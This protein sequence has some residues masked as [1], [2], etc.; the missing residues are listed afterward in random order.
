MCVD[1]WVDGCEWECVSVSR[2]APHLAAPDRPET[3]DGACCA[4]ARGMGGREGG[5][6]RTCV[7]VPERVVGCQRSS[8]RTSLGGGRALVAWGSVSRLSM[9]PDDDAMRAYKLCREHWSAAENSSTEDN[10]ANR[11]RCSS[12]DKPPS[13][14]PSSFVRACGRASGGVR[15]GPNGDSSPGG[16]RQGRDGTRRDPELAPFTGSHHSSP[17]TTKTGTK[18]KRKLLAPPTDAAA[19]CRVGPVLRAR[20]VWGQGVTDALAHATPVWLRHFDL[21]ARTGLG[22]SP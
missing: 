7:A 12:R 4:M 6:A 3:I 16:R 10:T 20:S 22:L 8:T 1:V 14:G 5:K 11:R 2:F 19:L 21:R 13:D 9:C 15:R 17:L 18:K